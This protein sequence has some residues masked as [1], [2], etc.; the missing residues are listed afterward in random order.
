MIVLW[1]FKFCLHLKNISIKQHIEVSQ[2]AAEMTTTRNTK[3]K[4]VLN[5]LRIKHSIAL[6]ATGAI[7]IKEFLLQCLHCVDGRY[8]GIRV[9]IKREFWNLNLLAQP[10]TRLLNPLYRL[11]IPVHRLL[12]PWVELSRT[13]TIYPRHPALHYT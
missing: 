3:M 12:I 7:T 11:L 6:L 9:G 2:L 1:K 8:K 5:S 13:Y 10:Y 4:F